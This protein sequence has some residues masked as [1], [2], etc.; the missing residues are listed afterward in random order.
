MREN[1]LIT[2]E[3]EGIWD[4]HPHT[5]LVRPYQ[6]LFDTGVWFL[7][8]YAEERSAIRIFNLS[9]IQ[10]VSLTNERFS[11]PGDYDYINQTDGSY[12]GVFIGKKYRFKIAFDTSSGKWIKERKWAADQKIKETKKGFV[13]EFTS[14]QYNRVLEW[15]LSRGAA[16]HP[17]EPKE[18]VT[19]WKNNIAGM[20]KFIKTP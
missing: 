18:L 17:L 14:T 10:N 4:D 6:L 8:G 13:I 2:F 5:R 16:A 15:L 9:R 1:R 19:E 12:F 11:L 3:Y 20:M 7:Y